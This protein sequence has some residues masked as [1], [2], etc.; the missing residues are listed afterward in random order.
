[1]LGERYKLGYTY[2][3]LYDNP[4]KIKQATTFTL[5]RNVEYVYDNLVR[6]SQPDFAVLATNL[7]SKN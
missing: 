4:L 1:M 5:Y 7:N 6:V 2:Y 3:W